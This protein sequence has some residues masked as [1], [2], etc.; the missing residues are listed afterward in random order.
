[1]TKSW[2]ERYGNRYQK[3]SPA[4]AETPTATEDTSVLEKFNDYLKTLPRELKVNKKDL[5]E[6]YKTH[7]AQALEVYMQER[8][9]APKPQR[10]TLNVIEVEPQ[11][12]QPQ[13]EQT[14]RPQ[15]ADNPAPARDAEP[16]PP[17]ADNWVEGYEKSF[18]NWVKNNTFKRDGTPKRTIETT[19]TANT[20]DVDLTPNNPS[21]H[22]AD[23]GATYHFEDSDNDETI[24]V[25]VTNKNPDK[26]LNYD[27]VYALVKSAKENG[28][29]TIEFKDVKTPE[30]ANM[31]MVASLQFDMQ[32]QNQPE[33]MIDDTAAYI[34]PK[35][36]NKISRY[37]ADKKPLP[38]QEQPKTDDFDRDDRDNNNRPDRHN[39]RDF[40][41]DN[42]HPN[43]R[44]RRDFDR[45]GTNRHDRGDFDRDNPRPRP[46]R[47][48]RRSSFE[49]D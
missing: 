42:E 23:K 20:L 38:R 10:K 29:D 19:K 43:R 25:T 45:D 15:Q 2:E 48:P 14:D 5:F 33:F 49:L 16:N 34:P 39:H 44:D 13:H 36:Q 8:T 21:P 41:R 3:K 12:A 32:M 6:L 46:R 18:R 28:V 24:N 31:L 11:P 35:L 9:A 17:A 27:Y 1:M 4:P 7:G 26:A 37:N 22:R 47:Q 30:F 40:E